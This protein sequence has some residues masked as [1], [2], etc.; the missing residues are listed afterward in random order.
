MK[1]Y[2]SLF[3]IRFLHG[4][5][6]RAAALAG[7]ATQFAWGF[8]TVLMFS[9]FYKANSAAFPMGFQ[10]L[11]S[12]I[13]LQQAFLAL[14][15]AW[16]LDEDI[17][18]SIRE[19]H[20]AYELTRP[21]DLYGVWF[22]KNAAVRLSRAVLRCMPI[23]LVAAFLRAPYG[24]ALPNSLIAFMWFFVTAIIGYLVVVAYCMLI[25]IATLYT[26]NP[27]GIRIVAVAMA[28][29]LA[30]G[31]IPLPFLPD[32]LR[33][34]LELTPFASMQNLP[35]LVY[36]GNVAGTELLYKAAL[37]LFWL[38]ALVLL[39]KLFMKAALK[40]TVVQGG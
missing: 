12:Y 1:S 36:S 23:L 6:Y 3:R 38:L 7:V 40:K 30:G 22:I 19:G 9:A 10:A 39:G 20:V 25:Y 16:F 18:L 37:Q 28:D 11:S 24:L 5:Q 33:K 21:L 34:V 2:L 14:F 32:G 29:F 26:L 15:M 8:M 13:W 27:M 35:L 31:I 4:L 17:F